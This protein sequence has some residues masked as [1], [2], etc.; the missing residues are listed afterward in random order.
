VAPWSSRR[1]PVAG[2]EDE[3]EYEYE[4]EYEAG[5]CWRSAGALG[6]TEPRTRGIEK[7]DARARGEGDA[8][9]RGA[10][11]D[12]E[13]VAATGQPVY[14]SRG[15][16][17]RP[18]RPTGP[19]RP[20]RPTPL[21]PRVHGDDSDEVAQ[22]AIEQRAHAHLGSP[23]AA[24]RSPLAGPGRRSPLA[25]RV[26]SDNYISPAATTTSPHPRR[27]PL[28]ARR[29]PLAARRSPLAA[30]RS[31]LAVDATTAPPVRAGA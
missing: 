19:T 15:G 12:Q 28:A 3:Y 6:S 14:G 30:R 29:S 16:P 22:R 9:P 21:E 8:C 17:T 27:S 20:T 18:T 31:P 4:Y 7:R 13:L 26:L 5:R 1:L 11:S 23:L 24:R 10:R 25:A 2:S